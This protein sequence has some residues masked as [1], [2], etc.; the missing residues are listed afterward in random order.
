MRHLRLDENNPTIHPQLIL[1][2]MGICVFKMQHNLIN[3][4][5]F[6]PKVSRG[7]YPRTALTTTFLP[8]PPIQQILDAPLYTFGYVRSYSARITKNI[9]I[10]LPKGKR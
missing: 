7:A 1:V 6:C 8:L 4:T 2:C 5:P 3:R 10:I 9:Y